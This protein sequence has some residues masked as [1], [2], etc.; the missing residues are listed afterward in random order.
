MKI[1]T[2]LK[3]QDENSGCNVKRHLAAFAIVLGKFNKT[4]NFD[5]VV[6]YMDSK[7]YFIYI[8]S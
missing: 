2:I 1:N 7:A 5:L 8:I 4:D 6:W 3:F